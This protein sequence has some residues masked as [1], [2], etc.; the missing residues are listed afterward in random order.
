M[1][2]YYIHL[3]G[4]TQKGAGKIQCMLGK[5]KHKIFKS[6]EKVDLKQKFK[7]VKFTSYSSG[8]EMYDYFVAHKQAV[9]ICRKAISPEYIE[10]VFTNKKMRGTIAMIGDVVV[11]FILHERIPKEKHIYLHLVCSSKDPIR[12]GIPV[13]LLLLKE[14]DKYAKSRGYKKL[15]AHCAIGLLNFYEGYGW[16]RTKSYDPRT[17]HLGIGITKKL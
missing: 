11:G 1:S 7:N 16:K 10:K 17:A 3:M 5:I 8:K 6:Q 4:K 12:K 13:A 14:L 15:K 2:I 9:D